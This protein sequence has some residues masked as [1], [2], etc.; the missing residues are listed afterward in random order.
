MP[1]AFAHI[2]AVN[3]AAATSSLVPLDMPNKAKLALSS[4]QK[5]IEFGCVSPDYPYLHVGC[6]EQQAWADKMHKDKVGAFIKKAARLVKDLG[7]EDQAKGFSWLCGFLAHVIADITIHPVVEMKVGKYA[8]NKTAHRVCEMNQ[9]AYIW[10]KLNIGEIGYAD[11]VRINIGSCVEA[12]SASE[13]DKVIR[14]IWAG[15]LSEIFPAEGESNPP[16]INEWHQYFLFIVDNVDEGHK[17]FPC[18][19]HVGAKYGLTYPSLSDLDMS[20]IENLETPC[21]I[22]HYDSIFQR[23]VENIQKYWCVLS[24]AVFEDGSMDMILDW[25]LDSGR[26]ENNELTAWS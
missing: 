8:E 16:K 11:R 12:G 22:E 10:P 13:V 21:G 26:C 5:Y 3:F 25:N 1:G 17:L 19:R 14:D 9:D 20:Y 24:K 4:N 15:A 6:S 23:A 18:A 7:C 2:A